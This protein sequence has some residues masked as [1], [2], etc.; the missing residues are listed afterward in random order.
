MYINTFR[1]STLIIYYSKTL[2]YVTSFIIYAPK[3]L[4]NFHH[5]VN[6]SAQGEEA[7]FEINCVI[8]RQSQIRACTPFPY[9]KK[10]TVYWSEL[11]IGT[12][13]L[14]NIPPIGRLGKDS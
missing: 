11:T 13:A 9:N 3:T 10:Q 6:N 4:P 5:C 1:L 8:L 14:G 12:E 2:F 7:N